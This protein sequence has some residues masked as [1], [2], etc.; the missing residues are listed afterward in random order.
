MNNLD[1]DISELKI[2]QA[3]GKSKLQFSSTITLKYCFTDYYK[4]LHVIHRILVIK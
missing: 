4:Q 3:K 2:A 1:F